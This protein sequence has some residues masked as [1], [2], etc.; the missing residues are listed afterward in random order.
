MT[1]GLSFPYP[2]RVLESGLQP[3]TSDLSGSADVD[4]APGQEHRSEFGAVPTSSPSQRTTEGEGSGRL[5][6]D[7]GGDDSGLGPSIGPSTPLSAP[8]KERRVVAQASLGLDPR[9]L[10]GAQEGVPH[11]QIVAQGIPGPGT[12]LAAARENAPHTINSFPDETGP[13]VHGDMDGRH[14]GLRD[15]IDDIESAV[16]GQ[17]Q[18][19][20]SDLVCED[21]G[22]VCVSK[23]SLRYV[24][25]PHP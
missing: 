8:S 13:Y 19:T 6:I 10:T 5:S 3:S 16:A 2:A 9:L 11:N 25:K 21:C 7:H 12:R 22:R 17:G 23:H 20:E 4:V 24:T 18:E 15:L 1:Y 14:Q